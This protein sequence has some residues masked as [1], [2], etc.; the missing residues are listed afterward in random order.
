MDRQTQIQDAVSPRMLTNLPL[1]WASDTD[2]GKIRDENE[3][4]LIVE[5]E[6]GFFLVSDGLGG[7]RG[8]AIASKVV[9]QDLPAMIENKLHRLRSTRCRPVREIFKKAVIEQSRQLRMEGTSESGYREMG[10]TLVMVLIRNKRAYIANLGD[11]R[12]Y[13]LRNRRF[14]QLSKDHSVISELIENGHI[15]AHEAENHPAQGQITHYIGMEETAV[16]FVRSFGL[17]KNDR[18]LLCSDGLTDMLDDKSIAAILHDESDPQKACQTLV[19]QANT[20]GGYDN[21]TVMILD[22][23]GN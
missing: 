3:D 23:L 18:L 14:T 8:G 4:A 2:K 17:M 19:K 16:P 21:I 1:R 15:E 5:P 9:V 6:I 7:H 20:A 10:A 11:S 22:Y 13:R 12:I